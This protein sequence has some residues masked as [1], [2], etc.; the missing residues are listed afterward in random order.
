MSHPNLES[1]VP[2]TERAPSSRSSHRR[3]MLAVLNEALQTYATGLTSRSVAR[4][5]DAC[6]VESWTA[7]DSTEWPFSFVNVCTVLGVDPDYIRARMRRLRLTLY[8]ADGPAH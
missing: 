7:S 6:Q 1:V 2:T 5:S 8:S 4:R 3:L